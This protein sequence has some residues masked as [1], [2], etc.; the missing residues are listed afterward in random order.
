MPLPDAHLAELER[1]R[2]NL[3]ANPDSGRPWDEVYH[4]LKARYGG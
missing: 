4:R 1:R 3:A 2:A